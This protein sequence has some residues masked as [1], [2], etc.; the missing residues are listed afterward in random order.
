MKIKG[1]FGETNILICFY[2]AADKVE[3]NCSRMT[4]TIIVNVNRVISDYLRCLSKD[5]TTPNNTNERYNVVC[6]TTIIIRSCNFYAVINRR[7][8]FSYFFNAGTRL[9]RGIFRTRE[10]FPRRANQLEALF[11]RSP[12]S[13]RITS[14]YVT[15]CNY[16][17]S[18]TT[19]LSA[20]YFHLVQPE[21]RNWSKSYLIRW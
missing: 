12:H 5:S 15:G 3:E 4:M 9:A 21:E 13:I 10:T 2:D 7:K 18:S 6:A 19:P 20:K 8:I 11:E 16:L 14:P 1:G 17:S